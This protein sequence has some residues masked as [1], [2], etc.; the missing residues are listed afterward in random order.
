MLGLTWYD[1]IDFSTNEA[2]ISVEILIR[3]KSQPPQEIL[4]QLL[5][6]LRDSNCTISTEMEKLSMEDRP[7]PLTLNPPDGGNAIDEFV[8]STKEK[9]AITHKKKRQ[10]SRCAVLLCGFHG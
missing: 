6:K 9:T 8:Q 3:Q 1:A 10:K 4:A 7:L 5:V 2:Q